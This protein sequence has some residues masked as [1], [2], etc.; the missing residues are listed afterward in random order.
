MREYFKPT[1]KFEDNDAIQSKRLRK[2]LQNMSATSSL[3]DDNTCS[4]DTKNKMP[5][6]KVSDNVLDE[7]EF[8]YFDDVSI[9]NE[10][11]DIETGD[12]LSSTKQPKKSPAK[13]L[14]T[15]SRSVYKKTTPIP[16]NPYRERQLVAK[17][18]SASNSSCT[19]SSNEKVQAKKVENLLKAA[20]TSLKPVTPYVQMKNVNNIVR[21]RML[22]RRRQMSARGRQQQ[23][24]TA[25]SLLEQ[26]EASK[27]TEL[28]PL[29]ISESD[30]D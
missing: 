4:D 18:S 2:I 16:N 20:A 10:F 30:S 22:S 28:K 8:S 11:F 24:K 1:I 15:S 26:A 5:N 14:I 19:I 25:V 6:S 13:S 27:S 7:N 9:E 21:K 3:Q 17:L 23:Q 12:E 29:Q